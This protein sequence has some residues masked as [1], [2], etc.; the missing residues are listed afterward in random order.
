M[1]RQ[2]WAAMKHRA[3][4]LLFSAAKVQKRVKTHTHKNKSIK[5]KQSTSVCPF[6]EDI[7]IQHSRACVG[8]DLDHWV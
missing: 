5:S 7:P 3:T 8:G 2:A 4:G 6:L 1:E